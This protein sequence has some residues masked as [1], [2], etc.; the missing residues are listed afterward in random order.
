LLIGVSLF[1]SLDVC[2]NIHF[3]P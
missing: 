3:F 2:W 1:S